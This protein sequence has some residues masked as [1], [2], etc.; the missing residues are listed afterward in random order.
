MTFKK[1]VTLSDLMDL[2][3][4]SHRGLDVVS[5]GLRGEEHLHRVG[6]TGHLHQRS[7]VE[8]LKNNYGIFTLIQN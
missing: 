3:N 2:N 4:G 5:L 7:V 8:V 1:K 6:S